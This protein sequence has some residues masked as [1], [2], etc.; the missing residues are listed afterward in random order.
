MSVFDSTGTPLLGSVKLVNG[1]DI[2]R[3]Y[4]YVPGMPQGRFNVI[5]SD[6]LQLNARLG[7]L[8]TVVSV[9][10]VEVGTDTSQ[11]ATSNG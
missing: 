7:D 6:G 2:L 4:E 3:K 8:N 1:E 9:K 5:R 11:E 10:Y